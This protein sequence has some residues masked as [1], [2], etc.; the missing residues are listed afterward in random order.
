MNGTPSLNYLSTVAEKNDY[1]KRT[2]RNLKLIFPILSL[3]FISA[4]RLDAQDYAN[5]FSVWDNYRGTWYG[6]K[7]TKVSLSRED[8]DEMFVTI[9]YK[10]TEYQDALWCVS[11]ELATASYLS[12]TRGST[13]T[14]ITADISISNGSLILKMYSNNSA[15]P[16]YTTPLSKTQNNSRVANTTT[17]TGSNTAGVVTSMRAEAVAR[18]FCEAMYDNNMVRAKSMMTAEGARRT[19]DTIRESPEVLASYKRRLHSAKY[20]V[21][22]SEYSSSIVTVRF[23]DPAF[24]Y[25]D[26]QGRWFGCAVELVKINSQWK[27]SDYG[28]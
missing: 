20:K 27:V 3:I 13:S 10:G 7:N 6:D 14:S 1:K 22:E 23:Y 16:F 11:S 26:K 5:W 25:L 21:I 9:V 4:V 15:S 18:Q 12:P 28:Y 17:N 24:P 19:P 2:M 8:G